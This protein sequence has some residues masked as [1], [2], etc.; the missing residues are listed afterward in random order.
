MRVG[1]GLEW[2]PVGA[3]LGIQMDRGGNFMPVFVGS[4]NSCVFCPDSRG[5]NQGLVILDSLC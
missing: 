5:W 4:N 3:D 2:D 1:L